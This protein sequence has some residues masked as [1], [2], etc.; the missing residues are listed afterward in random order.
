MQLRSSPWLRLLRARRVGGDAARGG[1][2]ARRRSARR[3][4]CSRRSRCRRSWPSPSPRGSGIGG[5]VVPALVSIALFGLAALITVPGLH[6][7]AA[8][9]AFAS[10]LV[11]TA[12]VAPRREAAPRSAPWPRLRDADQAAD[13]VAAAADR[14][15]RD[16]RRRAGRAAARRP[17]RARRRARARLRRRERAQPRARPR[18]RLADG[19]ADARAAGHRRAGCRRR[20][21]SSSGSRCRRSRSCCSP[22]WSTC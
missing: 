5:C 20:T 17:R 16:V 7:A 8:A 3:T 10:T 21:R 22:A 18:H 12:L 2:A 13:H 4:S 6:L 14:R 1:L 11:L 19:R 9:V 15:L